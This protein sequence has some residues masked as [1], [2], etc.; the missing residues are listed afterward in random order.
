M[1]SDN[2]SKL[3]ASDPFAKRPSMFD[4]TDNMAEGGVEP[5]RAEPQIIERVVEIEK[6]VE[7]AHP[8]M[9]DADG[10]T[11][12]GNI[13]MSQTGLVIP[14]DITANEWVAFYSVISN[15][16][17]S[18]QFI[19]GD[20]FA[21]GA[22]KFAYTYE[23]IAQATGYKTSTVETFASVCRNVPRLTRV[24]SLG[25]S[26]HRIVSTLAPAKQIEALNHAV[27]NQLSAR[28]LQEYLTE[29]KSRKTSSKKSPR[30]IYNVIDKKEFNR[31]KKADENERRKLAEQLRAM[32]EQLERGE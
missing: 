23:E 11:W 29:K 5:L 24:N 12:V 14:Q 15:I 17:Q 18:I 28:D 2:R 19:I 7:V 31:A 3:E 26:H 20:W 6:V 13:G 32:A 1:A 30:I 25:F 16:K 27:E 4:L 21:Y 10:V 9:T 22:D 8:V